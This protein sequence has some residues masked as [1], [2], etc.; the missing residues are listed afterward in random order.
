VSNRQALKE[1]L[2]RQLEHIEK[3]ET[4]PNFRMKEKVKALVRLIG[5]WLVIIIPALFFLYGI[6]E[7]V[8]RMFNT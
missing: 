8:R 4:D 2:K 7:F 6:V 1:F 3:Y 5:F